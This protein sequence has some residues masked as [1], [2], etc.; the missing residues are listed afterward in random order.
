[1]KLV[2]YSGGRPGAAA[3]KKAGY[4]GAIRYLCNSPDRG[5]VNKSLTKNEADDFRANGLVLVSNW[6]RG[7]GPTADFR[8]GRTGGIEDGKAALAAH[9][10]FGGPGYTPIYFSVDEDVDLQTWNK[11]VLPW[12]EGIASIIGKEWVGVYGGQ[13]SMWWAEEDGFRWRWQTCGWSRYDKNGNWNSA[14]PVQW[15][16]GVNIR[17]VQVDSGNV[18]GVGIDINETQTNDFGQWGVDRSPLAPK[19]VDPLKEIPNVVDFGITKRMVG[20]NNNGR[21]ST[22]NQIGIHTQQGN[23]TAVSLTNY[24]NNNEVSYNLAIDDEDTVLMVELEDAPW[25]ASGANGVAFHICGAGTFAEWTSSRWLSTDASDGLD[26]NA[27]LWR[28]A[29]ATAAACQRWGVPAKQ[30]GA[31]VYNANNWPNEKG[32]CGH[33]AFGSRGGGHFDPG[34]GFPWAE[35]IRRVQSFLAPA[36]NL[37]EA[38]AAV[39]KNWIGKRLAVAGNAGESIV[40]RNGKEIGRFVEYE[41]AHVYWKSGTNAAYAVPHGGIFESWA[42]LGWEAGELG[43]PI[44]RH[45]VVQ[46]GSVQAFQGGTLLVQA[47]KTQG[48]YVHGEIGKN[49]A[50]M[51]WEQSRLGYPLSNE[52]KVEGTDNIRQLFQ[53]G[54]LRWS[55]SGVIVDF[56]ETAG[57]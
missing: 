47:G 10:Q 56:N 3:I 30:V 34:T 39:A 42:A 19:P 55:P 28:M 8:R 26:E 57:V 20:N 4:A 6:Q 24:C 11:L 44:L 40:R 7:K 21:R 37:I 53:G 23:G 33:V 54:T 43:F 31:V 48:F 50:A 27:M 13:R 2:D 41:N 36:P 1:M 45:K 16:A 46:G 22:T 25:A 17:Q 49:Y 5:L 18:A 38:E 12:L 15:V 9:F 51:G 52:E 32:V 35:F 14:L 29:R